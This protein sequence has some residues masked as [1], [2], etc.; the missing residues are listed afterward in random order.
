MIQ[1]KGAQAAVGRKIVTEVD[2]RSLAEAI[3]ER[4]KGKGARGRDEDEF[5]NDTLLLLGVAYAGIN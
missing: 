3:S 1:E 4:I 5:N 2:R